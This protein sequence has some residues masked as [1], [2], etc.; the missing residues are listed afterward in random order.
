MKLPSSWLKEFV[1]VRETPAQLAEL[2]TFSGTEVTGIMKAGGNIDDK[3]VVAEVVT[4]AKHPNA[5]KLQLVT[6]KTSANQTQNVVCGAFN[7]KV[8]DKVPLAQAEAVLASGDK[9]AKA[10]ICGIESNGM[11]CAEDELGLGDDHSGIVILDKAA[12]LGAKVSSVLG[13]GE[14]VLDLDLTPNRP[15][16]LSIIGLAREVAAVTRNKL[17][18]TRYKLK[19]SSEKIKDHLAV[20]VIDKDLCPL[21]S[22]RIIK[23]ITIK[24]S[25]DW[26]KSRLLA[27]GVRP[28]NNIVDA[29]NYIMLLTGQPLHAFDAQ[30]IKEIVVRKAKSGEAIKTLDAQ[31]HKL[32]SSML[33]ITDSKQPIAIAGVMGGFTSEIKE[34]T[35][36][37]ILESAYF[38]PLS[39]RKT[40]QQL[41]LRS[42]SS[43]RFEKGID[44]QKTL[45]N[46]DK[47]SS[48]LAELSG[49]QVVAGQAV[50]DN[51]K[52]KPVVIDLDPQQVSKLLGVE[53]K[54]VQI[55]DIL[56][57]L[58]F[59]V[60]GDKKLK[61]EV[62]SFR[63]QD[64]K[65]PADLIEE[66]GRILDYNKMPKTTLIGQLQPPPANEQLQFIEQ[67]R[68][69]LSLA[70]MI[71]VYS[72]S[73]YGKPLAKQPHLEIA[74]PLSE[75]QKYLRTSFQ[76]VLPMM[77]HNLNYYDQLNLFEIGNLYFPQGKGGVK[78]ANMIFGL[79][80]SKANDNSYLLAKGILEFLGKKVGVK[81]VK[82][83]LIELRP[84]N[85]KE[86]ATYKVPVNSALFV[87]DT[88]KLRSLVK[89]KQY[90]PFSAYPS[91]E[92][93]L[94]FWVD[95]E[96]SYQEIK[97]SLKNIDPLLIVITCFD[98]FADK[99]NTKRH[100]LAMRFTW[101]S[102][103]RTL[104][105]E[106]VDV[107]LAK[108]VKELKNKFQIELRS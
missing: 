41:N 45:A 105:S 63:Q 64:V 35:K 30:G 10:V 40:S 102:E 19:E 76:Q 92:R 38:D 72:Y 15:D 18:E 96:Y 27:S 87:L 83:A 33:L 29:T 39:V 34:G 5:D 108:I 36:D 66:V 80:A 20:K 65:L 52:P 12:K 55:K 82:S 62:P 13:S 104:K 48:L 21:Y 69:I 89:P 59:K 17:A 28:I 86:I 53:V 56:T 57:R 32:D 98:V 77:A 84:V 16:C 95:K 9:L 4:I 70:K 85:A 88:A 100:S 42:E 60:S 90:Q 103:E 14:T 44:Y 25:P 93:D 99:Q 37:I 73:F 58:Q 79:V 68:D 67:V 78:E 11:L 23:G 81:D 106:E 107:T 3:V 47:A 91:V 6:V 7:F 24:E 22:A 8:G 71:E 74:N 61:I 101:Q 94:A 51:T 75:D 43:F 54:P 1:D 46:L 97:V 49:G 31:Q 50:A 2:L 26:L